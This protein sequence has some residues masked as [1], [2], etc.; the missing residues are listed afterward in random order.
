MVKLED[1]GTISLDWAKPEE[2]T[3]FLSKSHSKNGPKRVC[4]ILPGQSG[5]GENEGY[6]IA[7]VRTLM[8]D[9]FEVVV[10]NARGFGGNAY[11]SPKFADLTSTSEFDTMFTAIRE[12][13]GEDAELVGVGVSLGAN[14][15][16]KVAGESKTDFPLKAIVSVNNPFDIQ[17]VINLMRGTIYERHLVRDLANAILLRD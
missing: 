17:C 9:G 14:T 10:Y 8:S 15:L 11:T 2:N 6:L 12:R 7:L 16:L 4:L 13:A 5:R 3:E 1:G